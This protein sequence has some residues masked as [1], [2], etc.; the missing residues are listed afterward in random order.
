MRPV[1]PT[2]VWAGPERA[3]LLAGDY[4]GLAATATVKS[5]Q[6]GQWGQMTPAQRATFAADL[7]RSAGLLRAAMAGLRSA[8]LPRAD[9]TAFSPYGADGLRQPARP[10]P[11]RLTHRV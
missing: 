5:A 2:A 8:T 10:G 7:G 9:P 6:A 4:A 1:E 11:S 3:A